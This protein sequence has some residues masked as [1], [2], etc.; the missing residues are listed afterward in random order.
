MVND[1]PQYYYSLILR[2]SITSNILVTDTTDTIDSIDS[3]AMYSIRMYCHVLPCNVMYCH[4]VPC[5][6]MSKLDAG[7]KN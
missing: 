3:I 1:T 6:A 7:T 4:V 5:I 2:L